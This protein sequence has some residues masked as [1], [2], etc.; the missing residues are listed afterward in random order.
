M[1]KTTKRLIVA[2]VLLIIVAV[3]FLY[4]Y[5]NVMVANPLGMFQ[6]A[7]SG[8]INDISITVYRVPE[9]M[10]TVLP[11]DANALMAFDKAEKVVLKGEKCKDI[12]E[13]IDKSLKPGRFSFKNIN[14]RVC[15]LVE[16][17]TEGKLLE[18]VFWGYPDS[19]WEK[20]A[21]D[22][23][24]VIVNGVSFNVESKL[25]ETLMNQK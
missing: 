15:C 16:S 14:A 10:E 18:M 11:L 7:M 3:A 4:P 13:L 5:I 17:E 9:G 25:Y 1:K 24:G 6:K 2:S 20:I 8:D 22:T 12:L 19:F 21:G 23:S